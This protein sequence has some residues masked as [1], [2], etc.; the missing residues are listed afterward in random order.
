M[1]ERDLEERARQETSVRAEAAAVVERAQD[2]A[3]NAEE[4]AE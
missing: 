1:L 2:R 4:A 3:R